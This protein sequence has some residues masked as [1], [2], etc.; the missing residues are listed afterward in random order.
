MWGLQLRIYQKDL[1][2]RY[3]KLF[4]N[5]AGT[6]LTFGPSFPVHASLERGL[7]EEEGKWRDTKEALCGVLDTISLGKMGLNIT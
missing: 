5:R 7:R 3:W 2:G 6:S 4:R 1:T